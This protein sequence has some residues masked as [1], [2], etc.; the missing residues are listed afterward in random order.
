MTSERNCWGFTFNSLRSL[1]CVISY[2]SL[3]N[4]LQSSSSLRRKA[5]NVI[6]KLSPRF[7]S[8]FILICARVDCLVYLNNKTRKVLLRQRKTYNPEQKLLFSSRARVIAQVE[9]I[10]KQNNSNF[11][12]NRTNTF[13]FSWYLDL[14]VKLFFFPT[15]PHK[16]FSLWFI[17]FALFIRKRML[18]W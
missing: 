10:S 4:I 6:T 11:A 2:Q 9:R 1:F 8:F 17:V 15:H 16:Y 7:F 14:L 5:W 3:S 18:L 13:T 12:S